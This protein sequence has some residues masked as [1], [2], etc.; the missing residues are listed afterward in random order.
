MGG[1]N[2]AQSLDSHQ[3][4]VCASS[5]GSHQFSFDNENLLFCLNIF[6]GGPRLLKMSLYSR[7]LSEESRGNL[8]FIL[9]L[10]NPKDTAVSFF[11]HYQRDPLEKFAVPWAD[12][13]ELFS[14]GRGTTKI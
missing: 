4:F 6:S 10:R 13:I 1:L 7:H 14:Q 8:K 11:Y 9:G 2:F 12:F 5:K 3:F